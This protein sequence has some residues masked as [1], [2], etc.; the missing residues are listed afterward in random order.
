[1][2]RIKIKKKIKILNKKQCLYVF[3]LMKEHVTW[4]DSFTVYVFIIFWTPTELYGTEEKAIYQAVDTKIILVIRIHLLLVLLFSW[5][6]LTIKKKSLFTLSL[7]LFVS[8][9]KD[10]I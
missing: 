9:V 8:H 7:K 4:W 10:I 3:M 2:C 1:M 6:V 5:D